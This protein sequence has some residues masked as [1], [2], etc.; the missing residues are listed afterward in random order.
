MFMKKLYYLNFTV[1]VLA[2]CL[3]P[4]FA[5]STQGRGNVTGSY[6]T[7]EYQ[8]SLSNFRNFRIKETGFNTS[9]PIGLVRSARNAEASVLG[10]PQHFYTQQQSDSYKSYGNDLLGFGASVGLLVKSLRVEFEGS[11][12]RFD[13]KHL[14]NYASRDGHRYFAIPRDT[15]F[16]KSIPNKML[17][18]TVAKNNGISVASN[19]VN[20]CY[21][22]IKYSSFTPYVCLGVGGDFIELFD[23]MRI[24][25][26][27]QGKVGV[28]YP[29]TSRLVFSISGQYHRVVG[30][31]FKLLPLNQPV[32]L[33]KGER[34]S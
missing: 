34:W 5:L 1:L 25:L 30:S 7:I 11:Y 14:V 32:P 6:I 23:S 10:V 26:A 31:K 3:F 13:I 16:N 8:P 9:S 29:I 4:G 12:K 20:L 15:F 24:K 18:Y 22:L 28:S 17:G 19:M 33:K 27:Y 2:A 21:E